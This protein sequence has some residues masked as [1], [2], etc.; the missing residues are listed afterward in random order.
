MPWPACLSQHCFFLMSPRS[1]FMKDPLLS[2]SPPWD[3]P[4]LKPSLVR[5][6]QEDGLGVEVTVDALSGNLLL[7]LC[8]VCCFIP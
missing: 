7:L 4:W 8:D 1:A 3:A 2:L 5:Q 6:L